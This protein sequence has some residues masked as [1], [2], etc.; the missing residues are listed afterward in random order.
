MPQTCTSSIA[1]SLLLPAGAVHA[2]RMVQPSAGDAHTCAI[3][4]GGALACRGEV[5]RGDPQPRARARGSV[6]AHSP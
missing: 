5:R 3:R 1:A 2:Y 4:A 6:G